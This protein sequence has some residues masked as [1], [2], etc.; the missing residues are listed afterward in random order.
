MKLVPRKRLKWT[1]ETPVSWEA[2][3]EIAGIGISI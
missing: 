3:A 1:F 2:E